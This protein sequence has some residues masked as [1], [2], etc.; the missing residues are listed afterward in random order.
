MRDSAPDP[1]GVMVDS[2]N[3]D[4]NSR[5]SGW[6]TTLGITAQTVDATVQRYK[7]AVGIHHT[8]CTHISVAYRIPTQ[9]F[10]IRVFPRLLDRGCRLDMVPITAIHLKHFYQDTLPGLEMRCCVHPSLVTEF[11]ER[12]VKLQ[13]EK[14]HENAGTVTDTILASAH[15]PE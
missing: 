6:T 8:D 12:N 7:H 11:S 4:S 5:T 1:V 3:S 9:C 15:T 13:T 10:L 14:I 2:Q